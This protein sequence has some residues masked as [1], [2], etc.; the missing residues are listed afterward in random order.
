MSNMQLNDGPHGAWA[1]ACRI[2]IPPLVFNLQVQISLLER[3][4]LLLGSI[5]IHHGLHNW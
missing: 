3:E 1:G 4:T 2:I 5:L